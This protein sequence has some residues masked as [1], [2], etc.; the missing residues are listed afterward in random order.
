VA[1]PTTPLPA[2]KAFAEDER[3]VLLGYLAYHR[4]VLARKVD[5]VSD[6]DARRA[7]CAPSAL[8]LL[9]LIRHMTDVERWWFRR[10]QAAEDVPALFDE[11]EEWIV[12]A[13]VTVAD[14]LARYWEEIAVIDGLLEGATMDDPNQGGPE[15]GEHRLRRTI[16][17]MI[18]EYARHCGHAD[19]LREAI[20]GTTGD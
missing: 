15:P 8:T 7:A 11:E 9:G 2:A 12:P 1:E 5:G 19:L 17:H 3:S 6:E 10:V 16:V 18:E 13:D 20:D 4:A 14:A